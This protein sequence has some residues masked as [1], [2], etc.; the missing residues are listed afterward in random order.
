[1]RITSLHP[2]S[3]IRFS[4]K[5]EY[6]YLAKKGVRE[7]DVWDYN[8]IVSIEQNSYQEHT[9]YLR[10]QHYPIIQF[11]ALISRKS[12]FYITNLVL[13]LFFVTSTIFVSF[14]HDAQAISSRLSACATTLLTSINLRFVIHN[15]LP[16][17]PYSTYLDIYSMCSIVFITIVF[18]WH[19]LSFKQLTQENYIALDN[20]VLIVFAS[21]FLLMHV[22]LIIFTWIRPKRR[23]KIFL[24]TVPIVNNQLIELEDLLGY[25]R[26]A[27]KFLIN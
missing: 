26:S 20:Y 17:V 16:N 1:M 12:Q 21:V 19:A 5:Q 15:H 24:N 4:G 18:C 8:Q 13:P 2:I 23:Q 14:S 6:C 9:P 10:S 7:N 11:R 22:L 3:H 27:D 25:E